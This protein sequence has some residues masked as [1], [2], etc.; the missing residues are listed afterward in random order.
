MYCCIV[1]EKIDL[2]C[3]ILSDDNAMRSKHFHIIKF[4]A[5]VYGFVLC[6]EYDRNEFSKLV[7]AID[8]KA[9]IFILSYIFDVLL[10]TGRVALVVVGYLG[11]K[12]K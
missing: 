8:C 4:S 12:K 9:T 2:I 11:N 5:F 3:D 1:F 10:V 7:V 6:K